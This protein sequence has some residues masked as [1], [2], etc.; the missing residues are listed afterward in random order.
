MTLRKFGGNNRARLLRG[1]WPETDLAWREEKC[2]RKPAPRPEGMESSQSIPIGAALTA[3]PASWGR[4]QAAR[5]LPRLFLGAGRFLKW[6]HVL[7]ITR[8]YQ[9]NE[10]F[11]AIHSCEHSQDFQWCALRIKQRL[12]QRPAANY[13]RA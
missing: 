11:I 9:K 12:P 1:D 7:F 5:R 13:N 10:Y 2:E 6:T 8:S 4:L 3:G